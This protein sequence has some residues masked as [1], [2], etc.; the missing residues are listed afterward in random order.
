M[1][2]TRKFEADD[3]CS[4]IDFF[5]EREYLKSSAEHFRMQQRLQFTF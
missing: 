2:I 4:G 1:R 5:C 3:T